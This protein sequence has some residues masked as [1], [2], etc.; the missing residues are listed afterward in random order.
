MCTDN[1]FDLDV[2]SFDRKYGLVAINI[3]VVKT[4]GALYTQKCTTAGYK[5]SVREDFRI[6]LISSWFHVCED[7]FILREEKKRCRSITKML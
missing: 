7:G 1:S 6:D 5:Y 4:G 2:V 3:K